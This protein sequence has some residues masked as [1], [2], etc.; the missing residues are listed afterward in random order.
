[1]KG[2]DNLNKALL[3]I[4][5]LHDFVSP[6]GK[7]YCGESAGKIIPFI[8]QRIEEF[9]QKGDK[10]IFICDNHDPDDREFIKF[11]PHCI[12]DTIGAEIIS[13]LNFSCYRQEIVYKKRYSGFFQTDL[14]ER[15]KGVDQVFLVGV[16]TNI[17]VFFTAE[18]LCNR[19]IRTIVYIQGVTSFDQKAH[20]FALNQMKDVLGVELE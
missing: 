5:M 15:L 10:V 8:R 6:Q 19:D 14:A 18:E 16:C 20:Q 1:M 9:Y 4:D 13:E 17:C 2:A 3:V 12:T 7:L 11:P